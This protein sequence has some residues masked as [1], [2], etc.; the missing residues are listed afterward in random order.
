MR[1]L[2][3]AGAALVGFAAPAAA[4]QLTSPDIRDGAQVPLEQ[5]YTRCG[6]QNVSPAIAWSG[7]PAGTKSFA[8][9]AIDLDVHPN[10]WSHWIIVGLPPG[11]ASL[12][13]GAT[14]PPGAQAPM[15]DF[16]DAGYA[17]PCPPK[18]SGVHHYQ[19]TVWALPTPTVQFAPHA[20]AADVATTLEKTALAKGSIT[21]TYQR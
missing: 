16:G 17:G 2:A 21:A 10:E 7:A 15:T 1:R 12:G 18:G 14:L 3:L 11:A 19:F 8:V 6:G 9:T 5:V 4:L 20:T 13:K